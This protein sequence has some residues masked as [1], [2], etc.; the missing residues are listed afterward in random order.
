MPEAKITLYD[1]HPDYVR[2]H[3]VHWTPKT[4][5]GNAHFR[6]E[7]LS[8]WLRAIRA[9]PH[10]LVPIQSVQKAFLAVALKKGVTLRE[11]D[12]TDLKQVRLCFG[13]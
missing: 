4:V 9:L 13:F 7:P 1:K 2:D 8:D 5:F 11:G 12:I 6:S 3:A 10:P